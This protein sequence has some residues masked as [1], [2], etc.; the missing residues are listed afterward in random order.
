M[1]KQIKPVHKEHKQDIKPTM[2][3]RKWANTKHKP[4]N[5]DNTDNRDN[6]QTQVHGNT[7]DETP[8]K[9]QDTTDNKTDRQQTTQRET[10]PDA[11]RVTQDETR[12]DRTRRDKT[13]GQHKNIELFFGNNLT[14]AEHEQFR[15]QWSHTIQQQTMHDGMT[16]TT[17]VPTKTL[18]QN[19]HVDRHLG[20][21]W[22]LCTQ[23]TSRNWVIS[24]AVAK[25]QSPYNNQKF[26]KN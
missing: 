3:T 25:N 17:C 2:D 8:V 11:T 5:Q 21:H 12:Q 1:T 15:R 4:R 22:D 20:S 18:Y 16:L 13:G 24:L 10:T 14:Q 6:R 26:H 7:R 9:S 23:E 19:W